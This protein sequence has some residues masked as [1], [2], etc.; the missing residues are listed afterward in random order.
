MTLDDSKL[1]ERIGEAIGSQQEIA[2]WSDVKARAQRP[3]RARRAPRLGRALLIA[4]ALVLV[5]GSIAFALD[6]QLG[7]VL[8]LY[9]PPLTVEQQM[10]SFP[11]TGTLIPGTP[12]L[13][14]RL[15]TAQF[16]LVRL[17]AGRTTHGY[18][19]LIVRGGRGGGQCRSDLVRSRSPIVFGYSTT[20]HAP[21]WRLV[22]GHAYAAGARS[23]RIRFRHGPARTVA[24]VERFFLFELS[25][26]HA[27]DSS[28]PPIALDVLDAAGRTIGTRLHLFD[29]GPRPRAGSVRRIA[30]VRLAN[31]LGTA[32]IWSGHEA[33]G[34]RCF[35]VRSTG[36][37]PD[38]NWQC[39]SAVGRFGLR[40]HGN[41]VER[42]PVSWMLG[43]S[44]DRDSS[45]FAYGWV[46][47]SISRLQ[48]VFQDG[49]ALNI[50]LHAGYF[51]YAIPVENWRSG[52]RPSVLRTYTSA[53]RRTYSQFLDPRLACVYPGAYS[54]CG[55]GTG[56]SHGF[57]AIV[58]AQGANSGFAGT[59]STP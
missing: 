44:E 24:L 15:P 18:C 48:L 5:G 55:G 31:A 38:V 29:F 20:K 54:T 43:R 23:L 13:V 36:S 22:D 37:G 51:V 26:A 17:Y 57:T 25:P 6:G 9:R 16:G 58:T 33:R 56:T 8:G 3:E 2:G 52:H 47:P 46:S 35:G 32:T 10:Q 45:T 12:H 30:Q 21:G 27:E 1:A 41:G 50:P 59:T 53:G 42:A 11:G 49:T 4:A 14:M 40:A 34:A 28:N 19:E 7:E 39:G